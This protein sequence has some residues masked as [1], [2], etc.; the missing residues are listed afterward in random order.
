MLD[1]INKGYIS[2]SDRQDCIQRAIYTLP[3]FYKMQFPVVQDIGVGPLIPSSEFEQRLGIGRDFYLTEIIADFGE[4]K[5]VIGSFFN[6][7]LYTGNYDSLYRFEAGKELPSGFIAGEA[8]FKS[9]TAN[10]RFVDRQNETFPKLIRK[11]DHVYA[12]LANT[13]PRLAPGTITIVLKGFIMLTEP[14]VSDTETAMLNDSLSKPICWDFF[15]V[16]VTDDPHDRGKR[17]YVLE[18]DKIPRLILGMGAI[19]LK[20]VKAQLSAIDVDITDLSR[21][22]QMTDT[23]IPLQ[24][25]APRLTSLVDEHLYYLPTEY[26]F[27]PLGKMQFEINNVWMDDDHSNGAEI[28]ILTRTP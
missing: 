28:A 7:T 13:Q 24:F 27:A 15:K 1:T 19:N 26:Y 6:L 18:N 23:A 14:F 22:L 8:R 9:I 11:N 12:K 17:A 5:D 4:A 10:Q 3:F 25:V 2:D 21:R 20:T 16:K